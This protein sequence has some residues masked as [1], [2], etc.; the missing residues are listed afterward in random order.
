[1]VSKA[2]AASTS[3]GDGMRWLDSRRTRR[4]ATVAQPAATTAASQASST[5][6]TTRMRTPTTS[7]VAAA[8]RVARHATDACHAKRFTGAPRASR[9]PWRRATC[10]V[11]PGLAEADVDVLDAGVEPHGVAPLL[12]ADAGL[13]PA[14]ERRLRERHGVLVDADHA[15]LEVAGEAV[16]GAEVLRPHAVEEAEVG[17]VGELERLVRRGERHH[18]QDGAEDLLAPHGAGGLDAG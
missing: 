15:A 18:R 8:M 5:G 13:L 9:R 11:P 12:G 2:A 17:V 14:G 4:R 16:G 1:M 3:T 7:A 6:R 10:A